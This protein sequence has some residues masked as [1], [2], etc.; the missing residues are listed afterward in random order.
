MFFSLIC[1]LSTKFLPHSD[2]RPFSRWVCTRLSVCVC[3][4]YVYLNFDGA[5]K[6]LCLVCKIHVDEYLVNDHDQ[7]WSFQLYSCNA[8]NKSTYKKIKVTFIRCS[9]CNRVPIKLKGDS[10]RKYQWKRSRKQSA[11]LGSNELYRL[12]ALMYFMYQIKAFNKKV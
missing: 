12:D 6:N 7:S 8:G 9:I 10:L 1:P 2:P 5:T 4:C 11:S 3:V